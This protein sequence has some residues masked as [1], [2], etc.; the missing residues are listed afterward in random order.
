MASS[1]IIS[2]LIEGEKIESDIL[3]FWTPKSLWMVTAT[4]KLEDAYSLEGKL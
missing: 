2:Q 1:P 3:F 4:M